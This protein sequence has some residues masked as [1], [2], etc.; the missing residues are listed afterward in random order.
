MFLYGD[1]KTNAAEDNLVFGG[2]FVRMKLSEKN[3][4]LSASLCFYSN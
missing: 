2:D 3:S 1:Y 4:Y